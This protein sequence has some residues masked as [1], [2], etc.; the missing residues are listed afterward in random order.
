MDWDR[1]PGAV[2]PRDRRTFSVGL[3]RVTPWLILVAMAVKGVDVV[4]GLFVLTD[5]PAE[6]RHRLH[7][8]VDV[9]VTTALVDAALFF[10]VVAAL[11]WVGVFLASRVAR[12]PI[13]TSAYLKAAGVA[14]VPTIVVV[15]ARFMPTPNPALT[16]LLLLATVPVAYYV[17]KHAYELTWTEAATALGAMAPLYGLGQLLVGRCWPA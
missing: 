15:P 7:L 10:A 4:R 12:F 9:V 17:I 2:A 6:V 13:N 11:A 8:G 3:D 1:G 14:A 5:V 16:A